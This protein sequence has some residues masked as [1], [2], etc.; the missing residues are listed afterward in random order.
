MCLL[1]LF[2]ACSYKIGEL[3][4]RKFKEAAQEGL[5]KYALW[6]FSVNIFFRLQGAIF[7]KKD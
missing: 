4:I 2:K 3:Q 6:L 5:G 7:T 1:F